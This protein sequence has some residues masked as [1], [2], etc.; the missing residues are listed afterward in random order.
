MDTDA[1]MT[2]LLVGLVVYLVAVAAIVAGLLLADWRAGRRRVRVEPNPAAGRELVR[3]GYRV[4]R[5]HH[6]YR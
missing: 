3:A 2:M 4:Q 6:R 5:N 1:D